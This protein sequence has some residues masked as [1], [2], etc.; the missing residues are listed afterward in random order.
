MDKLYY[1]GYIGSVEFSAKDHCLYGKVQGLT[2]ELISYEGESVGELEEDFQ[3]AVDAYLKQCERQGIEPKRAYCGVFNVR[4]PSELHS[5]A[6]LLAERKNISLNALVN[7][8]LYN[9]VEKSTKAAYV[10]DQLKYNEAKWD[11]P[12]I[13]VYNALESRPC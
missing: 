3:S 10:I 1:K 11:H 12:L 8:A 7:V 5:R 2:G 9:Y 6:A 13:F 4:V